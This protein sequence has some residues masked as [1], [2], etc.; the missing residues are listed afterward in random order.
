MI[1][2]ILAVALGVLTIVM[3]LLFRRISS[4]AGR[5]ARFD[6]AIRQL[7]D[8]HVE[9]YRELTILRRRSSGAARPD[10]H[11]SEKPAVVGGD[12]P[13]K[14]PEPGDRPVRVKKHL[15]LYKGGAIAVVLAL[16]GL[17]REA[18]REHRGYVVSTAIGATAAG[19]ATATL[20][21]ITPWYADADHRPPSSAPT[22]AP[23]ATVTPPPN[24]P[25]ASSQSGLAR[26]P[27]PA[28]ASAPGPSESA[29]PSS[30]PTTP[31]AQVGKEPTAAPGTT[32]AGPG[33]GIT[34]TGSP[35]EQESEDPQESQ[36]LDESADLEDS[37]DP[38][39]S[40][41]LEDSQ[42]QEAL[43]SS[44]LPAPARSGLCAG[45]GVSPVLDVELCL[46]SL[47]GG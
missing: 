19:A 28:S 45:V 16:P 37:Q 14:E 24:P 32:V 44:P 31:V 7:T 43:W 12:H 5:Q 17:L 1:E 39:D 34:P 4:I 29:R 15:R 8:V 35:D 30:V 36:D 42:D 21:V 11:L 9:L 2:F 27:S 22:T 40:E 46:P 18:L 25:L 41:D 33:P 10:T 20:L 13:G 26:T 47:G 23:T 3:V 38:E 6:D